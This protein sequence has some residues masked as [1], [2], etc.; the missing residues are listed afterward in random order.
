MNQFKQILWIEGDTLIHRYYEEEALDYELNL[1]TCDCWDDAY[2]ELVKDFERWSAIIMQPKSKLHNGSLRNVH[3][4]LP[5]AFSDINVLCATKGKTIPWYILTDI[6]KS[7]FVD[8]ILDSRE[9]WDFTWTKKYYDSS[10]EE[11]RRFLFKRIKEQTRQ[12]ERLQVK[13]GHYKD[14]FDALEYLYDYYLNRKVG[15]IIEEM[16]VSICFGG[17][18]KNGL[19]SVRDILEYIFTSMVKNEIL[20]SD[21]LNIS[22]K[23]NNNACCRLLAGLDTICGNKTYKV[24]SPIMNGI[25][26]QNVHNILNLGNS[27]KHAITNEKSVQLDE[28]IDSV[29]TNNLI[30][31]CALQLCDVIIW[32]KNIIKESQDQITQY[33][34]VFQWWVTEDKNN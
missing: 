14:V 11:E 31:S 29:G 25:M 1:V 23:I 24:I 8:M 22:K 5:K 28:Y 20:P 34:R 21:L 13:S 27:S 10:I 16:L 3:Q 9:K 30:N 6:D 7:E 33:G 18:Y 12:N 15:E 26:S 17:G 19:G 4:F 32:Y 2:K